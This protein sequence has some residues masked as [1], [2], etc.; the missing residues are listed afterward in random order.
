MNTIKIFAT[1]FGEY[2]H[3][4]EMLESRVSEIDKRFRQWQEGHPGLIY[5]N[6]E[7]KIDFDRA[8]VY[9]KVEA[10]QMLP[11]AD[12]GIASKITQ[13]LV[14]TGKNFVPCPY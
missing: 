10:Q 13:N 7:F 14:G 3:I 8:I 5:I 1:R 9:L 4:D 12:D 6:Q 11:T 2:K